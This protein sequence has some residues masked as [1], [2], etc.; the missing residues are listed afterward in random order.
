M[1]GTG[2][3]LAAFICVAR[4]VT[5]AGGGDDLLGA[6]TGIAATTESDLFHPN[7]C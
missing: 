2:E 1:T 6:A 3:I 4:D 7:G 5:A